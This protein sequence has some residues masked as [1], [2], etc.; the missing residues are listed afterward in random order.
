MVFSK[1]K[2]IV[3]QAIAPHPVMSYND[4]MIYEYDDSIHFLKSTLQSK[5]EVNSSYS[6]RA[7]AKKLG[8]SAGALSSILN[9][10]KKLSVERAH[11]VANA[12][13]LNAD[14]T[15]YF[16]ALVQLEGAKSDSLKI[17]YL[18]KVKALNP[19]IN[20]SKNLKQTLLTLE[21]FK[22]ISDWYGLAILELISG[23]V[24]EWNIKTIAKKMGLSKVNVELTLERL[25]K[26]ELIEENADGSY[27]RIAETVMVQS[28]VPSDALKKYY[29]GVHAESLKSVFSQTPSEKVIG[30][31]VF[32]FDPSQLEEVRELTNAYLDSLNELAAAGINKTE[33]Y[34]A[35]TNVFKLTQKDSI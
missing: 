6:L 4:Y 34:Q 21:H 30:A 2:R 15:E 11:E 27:K 33:I 3:Y 17:Q 24:G 28:Q 22:L 23:P 8:L 26:L 12:L 16:M 7:F 31:Q 20:Q 25:T 35:I 13:G 1:G 29:E 32:A 18:E 14:A 10:K 19:K 5:A 9:R